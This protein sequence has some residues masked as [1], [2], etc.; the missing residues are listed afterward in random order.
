MYLSNSGVG[1]TFKTAIETDDAETVKTVI[2]EGLNPNTT[3]SF[4]NETLL[5]LAA[6]NDAVESTKVATN[7]CIFYTRWY[8]FE[9]IL[10]RYGAAIDGDDLG[11]YNIFGPRENVGTP[12]NTAT[13]YG[14]VRIM[15]VQI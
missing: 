14:S 8:C 9:Q 2:C 7:L 11:P 1:Q 4:L 6:R 12:L 3:I 5:E 10:L 15:E 13:D